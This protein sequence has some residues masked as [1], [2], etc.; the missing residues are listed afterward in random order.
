[1]AGYGAQAFHPYLAVAAVHAWHAKKGDG[2]EREQAFY[3]WRKAMNGGMLKIL[4]KIGIST[5]ASYTGAQLF[6][7]IG[8][9]GELIDRAFSGT[10][11]R[12]GGLDVA[13]IGEETERF[14]TAARG[15]DPLKLANY[16][17]I[18]TRKNR[19]YHSNAPH[20]AKLLQTAVKSD[21]AEKRNELYTQFKH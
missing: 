13:E 9:N 2:M 1:L 12:L 19:E 14:L 16:G 5:L 6:E 8:I 18:M 21:D 3:N 11:S 20:I 17:F 7:A 4:S 10:P 15:D